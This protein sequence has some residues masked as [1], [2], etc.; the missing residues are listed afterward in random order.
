MGELN[1][2]KLIGN[3]NKGLY[4]KQLMADIKALEL[5]LENDMFEKD[6]SRVGIE[7]EFCLVNEEWEPA[8]NADKILEKL[9]KKYF[10]SE[11]ALY[12]L[13]INMEPV[14]FKGECFSTLHGKLNELL[15]QV[16]EVAN[17][18]N[19][20]LVL[21][22]ILPTI[23]TK[24]LKLSYMTPLKRYQVLN[25]A[26]TEIRKNDIELHIKG[27]DELNLKHDSILYEGCNTSFQTH[28]QIDPNDFADTY[29]WA[30]A[31]AGPVLSICTNS[32]LLMGRELWEESRIALFAQSVD[33]RASTFIMNERES[34][35]GFGNEW[36]QGS[37][38]DFF[39]DSV[40]RFRSI[41]TSDFEN[42]SLTELEQGNIPKLKALKLHNGTVYKWN[43]LCYGT[44][45]G[46][47][48][49][50]L[51]NRYLPSGPSTADEMAN[52][53]FWVG[54]M[55]GRPKEFDNVHTI[56]DFKDV[57][58]NFFNAARY[59]M[60]AQFYWNNTLIS[61]HDLILDHLLPMAYRGL[62]SMKVAPKDAEHYLKIIKHRVQSTNGSRWMVEGFRKLKKDYKTTDALK[63]LTATIYE[64]QQKGYAI[65]A[66]QLPRGD[67]FK[68]PKEN[69]KVGER[70]NL[71]TITAQENDSLELVLRMMQWKDIHHVPI[72]DNHMDLVGLLTWT[73]VGK[74]LDSP[75]N[76]G[77]NIQNIMKRDL[78]TATPATPL[79]EAKSLMQTHKINC[80]PVVRGKKLVGIITSK[81]F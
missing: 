17:E 14:E 2:E 56:M 78:V 54:L 36:A 4:L 69:R 10:T 61:S 60:A 42:D 55:K 50:R 72:L 28:L 19:T 26:I 46:K 12:N 68:I 58:S 15:D 70:M 80:L 11:L 34:R 32:P 67:E 48:H 49:M 41:L 39:K 1:V 8:K 62:Y 24:H 73:D 63:I 35:V 29:N 38:V 21:T 75:E 59:G 25:E 53:M 37:V 33:T 18:N 44:T 16:Q 7:Q 57:K 74:Y 64:R 51:E 66:W 47:P 76:H 31:I 5:M 6:I 71:R 22:G 65:D 13:E 43:R 45:N 23:R 40:I 30:Q 20:K 81:D 9:N 79:E 52:M 27:V 3:P 77:E